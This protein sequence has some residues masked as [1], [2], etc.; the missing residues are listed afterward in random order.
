MSI[1]TKSRHLDQ[2][3]LGLYA[4]GDLPIF[5]ATTVEKHLASCALCRSDLRQMEELVVALRT[6]TGGGA[7]QRRCQA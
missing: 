1:F 2:G 4:L 3:A 7:P 6:L 5:Q